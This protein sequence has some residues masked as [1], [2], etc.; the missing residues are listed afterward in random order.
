MRALRATLGNHRGVALLITLSVTVV[1]VATTLEFNRRARY[2]LVSAAAARDH[3]TMSQMA[4]AGVHLAMAILVKDKTD[5]D[6]DTLMDDWANAEKID[7][8]LKDFPFETGNLLIAISDEMGKIKVNALVNFPEGRQFN[9]S[10]RTLWERF[11]Q[12]FADQKELDLELKDD[13][14]P[15]AII[16][17]LKD[18]IDHGDDDA[19]TGLSGAESS[20]YLDRQ[21]PYPARNAPIADLNELLLVKGITPRLLNG[22][23]GLPGIARYLTVQ[24]LSAGEGTGFSFGGQINVNTAELPVLFALVPAENKDLVEALDELRRDIVSGKQTI[25]LTSANWMTQIP[26]L[27][28]LRIDPKLITMASDVFRLES[29]ALMHDAATTVT[30][31]VQRVSAAQ[32]GKWTCRVLSWKVQ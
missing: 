11:L 28:E 20:Y 4:T 12:Y 24:G 15:A 14:E 6:T 16:N 26:G 29:T 32:T 17:S 25:D 10:Q 8:V 30:A 23:Q 31:V 13:S 27:A 3:L 1:L 21:P 18:W 7:E 2:A 22:Q 19:I 5:N 9:E